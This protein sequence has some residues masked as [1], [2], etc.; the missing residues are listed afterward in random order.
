MKQINSAIFIIAF[1]VF[2]SLTSLAQESEVKVVD[3]VV[4]QVNDGVITLSRVKREMNAAIDSLVH[5]GKTPEQ[6]RTE[7]EAKKGELIANIINEELLLQKG[8]DLDIDKEVD[9]QINQRFLEIMKQ[10]N[11]K[12]LDAL[13]QEM[14]KSGVDPTDIREVWRKQFTREA[15]FQREVDSKVYS[16]LNAKEIKAY[17]EA[18]KAKFTRPETISISEI[19][20]SFAGRD[21]AA[22]REKAKQLVAKARGGADF[23]ALVTENS[24]R[25]DV[26][27]TKG[28]NE[29]LNIKDLDEKFVKA[30]EKVQVGG[31]TDPI[32]LTEGIE[33]LRVDARTKASSESVY[34]ESEV[35][36]TL[37]Y[38]R[39]PEE[40]KKYMATLRT[41]SYIK[42]NETYR[43][44]VA[45]IL[46]GDERKTAEVK[47]S[48]K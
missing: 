23:T 21:E 22:T 27:T 48:D 25:S 17:F 7:I 34:D 8:K 24:D 3:E 15:V 40:R 10:Q 35:R 19:F 18:N 36:K 30:L 26:K 45:P 11:I 6:A 20:L 37:T 33:I 42:I 44:L 46:F 38:E 13:Y 14:T 31:V 4:A 2:S 9:A 5:D 16:G 28:K 41:E 32:E 47:K 39:L 29:N 1:V 43:P 12:T